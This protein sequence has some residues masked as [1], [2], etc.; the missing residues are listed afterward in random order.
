MARVAPIT[1]PR[2][3]AIYPH[4]TTPDTKFNAAGEYHVKL[5]IPTALAEQALIPA[6]D[7]AY[8]EAQ[9]AMLKEQQE[10]NP[11]KKIG[12]LKE[13]PLPYD[14]NPEND[15]ETVIKLKSKAS[16]TKDNGDVVTMRPAFFDAKGKP[17]PPDTKIGGGSVL[18]VSFE[19]VP[20]F[21]ATVGAGVTL[22]IKAVQVIELKEF[23][24]RSA[25]DYGFEQ[26][27]GYEANEESGS[28]F[29]EAK[30]EGA[31]QAAGDGSDF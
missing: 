6:I 11:K 10:K 27:E 22:R 20:Y 4:L 1:T 18:R 14:T 28:E 15:E 30:P 5:A 13:A 16:F 17:L 8:A 3:R 29:T 21:T 25:E 23:G 7:K 9:E 26:E 12:T 31:A 19:P 24:E 2:G